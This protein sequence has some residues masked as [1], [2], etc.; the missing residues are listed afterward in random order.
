MITIEKHS[1][2]YTLQVRQE[3]PISLEDAWEF[4]SLPAN[5]SKI[6]PAEMKFEITSGNSNKIYQGQIIS[7]RISP[8]A[9]LNMNWVTEITSVVENHLFVDEQRYGPYKM[10]HHEHHFE[11]TSNGTLIM[12]KVSYKL[13]FGIIGHWTHKL[14]IKKQL[15]RIFNFRYYTLHDIF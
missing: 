6:T 12:D 9:G 14:F 11:E 2:I 1:G 8:F 10:W 5:L 13:P 7:Y 3:L 15:F 4:F